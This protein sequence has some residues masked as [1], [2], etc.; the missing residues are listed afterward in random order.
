MSSTEKIV[1]NRLFPVIIYDGDGLVRSLNPAAARLL[2]A[3]ASQ[4]IGSRRSDFCKQR[5]GADDTAFWQGVLQEAAG[6]EVGRWV[7]KRGKDLWLESQFVCVVEDGADISVHEVLADVTERLQTEFAMRGQVSAIELSHAVARYSPEGYIR[8]VNDEFLKSVGYRREAVMGHHHSMFIDPVERSTEGYKAFWE[9]LGA[10]QFMS[11]EYRRKHSDGHDIWFQAVYS[12]ILDQSGQIREIVEYATDVTDEKLRRADY[13]WQVNAIHKSNAVITF[14]MYGTILDA[15]PLFLEATGYQLHEIEG[16]HHKIFVERSYAHGS[17]YNKFWNDLRKGMHRSGLFKR[18]GK[19]GREIWLQATYNPIFDTNGTPIK[20]VKFASIVTD[21]KLL[22]AEQQGQ[23]AAIN[24]A[25]CVI[26]FELDGTIIDANENF[27][28]ATGYR[29]AEVRGRHHKMFV[30]PEIAA[31]TAY[32][33]FWR[34]LAQGVYKSGQFRRLRKDGTDIWLQASYNP[35][36]DLSGRV[37]KVVKYAADIT[38]AK[39]QQV[40]NQSQ[41]AA[42]RRSQCVAVF[43]LDGKILE[44]NDNL[45]QSLGYESADVI[46]KHHSILVP[47]DARESAEYRELWD[48][49]RRGEFASGLHRRAGRDGRDVWL[50]CSYNPILDLRGKPFKI[51]KIASDVTSNVALA[52]AF[53]EAKR[54]AVHDHATSLP[55]RAKLSSFLATHLAHDAANLTLFYIDLD[56]FKNV[57]D[58]YGHMAGDR[59][60]GEIADRLRRLLRED[61]LAARVGG[62]EFVIAAPG[63]PMSEVE[64]FAGKVI[65]TLGEPVIVDG[66]QISVGL[67]LGI[68]LAPWDATSPDDLL[69]AA[70]AAL[71]RSKQH[72]R[73]QYSFFS[74]ELN[75]KIQLRK[76]LSDDMRHSLAAGEFFLEYQPRYDTRTREIKS[77]E[78]L[79]RWAHPERGKISPAD[80]I[81]LA[82]QNGLIVPLGAWIL[83]TACNTAAT[84]GGAGVSVNLSPVQFRDPELVERVRLALEESGLPAEKLEL[85]ITEGV[86]LDDADHARGVLQALKQ[87]GVKLAMD[88]FGTG[89]SSLS[90]LRNFPFDVL[91]IDQ[92]FIKDLGAESNARPIVQAILGLGQA[93]G[94]SVT[95]EGVETNEQLALLTMD[96]CSEVQGFLLSRPQVTE[97]IPQLL[98]E[99]PAAAL[100]PGASTRRFDRSGIKS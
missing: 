95:A 32:T 19:D 87:L 68:A 67:S 81:P 59:L 40:D 18:Y 50:Q 13:Q 88:D 22:Q 85:E 26:S 4:C 9:S 2:G 83:T 97:K 16:R 86:L 53:E 6:K 5:Q 47:R 64:R 99:K 8:A 96:H 1:L 71:Y 12:P 46:G 34:E 60:L 48:T 3:E 15:N 70:D 82:E 63:L 20:V 39:L 37:F 93:L 51:V 11:G 27:L 73:G 23:I 43:D 28:K 30:E 78:A 21:E 29:F 75:E 62:D 41:I 65:N 90:Y 66:N 36:R 79:V 42:I 92:S 14:D 7:D 10:G 89:Y 84:W 17:D 49:L 55:N 61:Q 25:E 80:F 94:L 38:D 100:A 57:N 91:K 54:L 98:A 56:K 35:I 24:H 44:I 72:G 33:D 76:K 45:L 69:R 31:S 52:E 58:A 77:A 74:D